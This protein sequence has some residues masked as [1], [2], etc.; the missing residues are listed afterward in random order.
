M[1]VVVV[2]II[3]MLLLWYSGGQVKGDE[4]SRAHGKYWWKRNA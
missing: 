2:M 4:K 1:V 3:I